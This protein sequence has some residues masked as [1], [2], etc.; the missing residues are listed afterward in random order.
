MGAQSNDTLQCCT[1]TNVHTQSMVPSFVES[2]FIKRTAIYIV[3]VVRACVTRC[4]ML[5]PALQCFFRP[6]FVQKLLGTPQCPAPHLFPSQL[7]PATMCTSSYPSIAGISCWHNLVSGSW[8]QY[9][10]RS[11]LLTDVQLTSSSA[12]LPLRMVVQSAWL[13]L[14]CEPSS[15]HHKPH[16]FWTKKIQFWK[17]QHNCQKDHL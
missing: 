4:R 5:K 2:I 13:L 7:L 12:I 16:Q 17:G 14:E 6:V 8:R 1:H 10:L 9:L 11:E 15:A 3:Q